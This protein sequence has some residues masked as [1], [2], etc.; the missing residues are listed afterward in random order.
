ML[1]TCPVSENGNL[2]CHQNKLAVYSQCISHFVA[3]LSP[4]PPTPIQSLHEMVDG[5]LKDMEH[6]F[7]TP[8]TPFTAFDSEAYKTSVVGR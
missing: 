6:F 8:I 1:T 7:S 3:V 5:E 4:P 2:S